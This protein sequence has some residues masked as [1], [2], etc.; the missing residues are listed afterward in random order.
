MGIQYRSIENPISP[1]AAAQL[2]TGNALAQGALAAQAILNSQ[3]ATA[4]AVV[5]FQI[6][7]HIRGKQM[8]ATR[9]CFGGLVGLVCITPASGVDGVN[10]VPSEASSEF[11]SGRLL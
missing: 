10:G 11:P 1:L 4:S 8:Q 6:A 7:D 2:N 9:L 5:A 3:V